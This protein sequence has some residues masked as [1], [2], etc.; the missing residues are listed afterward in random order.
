VFTF[1][2]DLFYG[3]CADPEC[4]NRII[5][6]SEGNDISI[7]YNEFIS[8]ETIGFSKVGFYL[9]HYE[10]KIYRFDQ[11]RRI[12]RCFSKKLQEIKN[13]TIESKYLVRNSGRK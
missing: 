11:D 4:H 7:M 10:G 8:K 13:G 2:T 5:K 9:V 12:L 6:D 1:E 3:I